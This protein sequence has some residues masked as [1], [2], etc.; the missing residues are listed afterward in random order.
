MSII[1]YVIYIM[2]KTIYFYSF[3]NIFLQLNETNTVF[4]V[5][6]IL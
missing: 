3:Y 2:Y 1:L 4:H 6:L 5:H